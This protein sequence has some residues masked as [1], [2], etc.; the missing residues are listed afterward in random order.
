MFGIDIGIT[1][2][3]VSLV[4]SKGKV[5]DY[6]IL[7]G[8]TSEQDQWKRIISM[9]DGIVEA[10]CKIPKQHPGISIKPLVSLEEPVFVH[11]VRNYK[12]FMTMAMLYALIR[13]KLTVRN[14]KVISVH[15]LTVKA[16]AR[17]LAFGSKKNLKQI[18]CVRGKL[19]KKGMIRAYKKLHGEEPNYRNAKG[20][21][22]LADSCFI[23]LTGMSKTYGNKVSSISPKTNGYGNRKPN[24]RSKS[25]ERIY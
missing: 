5:L 9:A 7:S 14:F 10:V 16:L 24:L 4:T 22:T 17:K 13:N 21:E 1:L 8:D 23:A 19:T 6:F 20:R 25:K 15:P 18:Y 11:R 3:S 12:S 2:S